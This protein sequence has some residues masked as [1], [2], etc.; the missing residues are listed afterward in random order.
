MRII[1]APAPAAVD[2]AHEIIRLIADPAKAATLIE[3]LRSAATEYQAAFASIVGREDGLTA[4]E[5]NVKYAEDA[6]AA[7]MQKLADDQR[8]LDS[9]NAEL[10]TG[11]ANYTLELANLESQKQHAAKLVQEA[12][13]LAL[14]VEN[15]RIARSEELDERQ[16]AL[17]A[18]QR[19][20][21]ARLQRLREI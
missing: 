9:A 13:D 1:N 3:D 5:A 12:S 6:L 11:R 18:S 10:A 20:L 19:D 15:E 17:A 2:S 16:E 7:G 14:T 8:A 21:E 4:R